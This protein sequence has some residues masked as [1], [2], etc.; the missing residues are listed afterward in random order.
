L[1]FLDLDFKNIYY[2]INYGKKRKDG[3]KKYHF[4]FDS[5]ATKKNTPIWFNFYFGTWL[6]L[7]FGKIF[8]CGFS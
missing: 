2:N 6:D 3:Q 4:E 5:Q 1:V 7:F 8:S